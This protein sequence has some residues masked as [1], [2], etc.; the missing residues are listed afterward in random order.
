MQKI[1]SGQSLF[2]AQLNIAILVSG[3][4]QV[5]I[6]VAVGS[7]RTVSFPASKW[8]LLNDQD[9]KSELILTMLLT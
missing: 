8:I 2:R 4:S 1:V 7:K 5:E 6:R 9:A 3:K